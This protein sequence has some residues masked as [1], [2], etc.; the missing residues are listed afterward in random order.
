[1][2]EVVFDRLRPS[3][4]VGRDFVAAADTTDTCSDVECFSTARL[5]VGL[6]FTG[7]DSPVAAA[8]ISAI[9]LSVAALVAASTCTVW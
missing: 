6:D 1:M 7:G 9:L 8:V 4:G 2:E 3:V 5:E